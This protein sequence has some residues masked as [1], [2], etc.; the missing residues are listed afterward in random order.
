MAECGHDFIGG[1]AAA[2][3]FSAVVTEVR[4][5]SRSNGKPLFQL[6]LSRSEFPVGEGDPLGTL[7]ATS[8]SGAV[9]VVPITAVQ[10]DSL[11]EQ[12]HTT[13]KPLQPG[14]VVSANF[15]AS[16]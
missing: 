1:Q 16:S 13:V 8:R 6:A 10:V 5:L 4:E 2:R 15:L 3:S 9:L 11:G 7:T 14:T 12:W